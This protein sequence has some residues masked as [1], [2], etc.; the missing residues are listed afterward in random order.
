[1]SYEKLEKYKIII[2][3]ELKDIYLNGP[4]LLKEPICYIL[5]GGG[6]RLRPILCLLS[7]ESLN[8]K[9]IN[10]EV[11]SVAIAVEL[12]HIFTLIHDDIMDSDTMRHG[13]ET[14]HH[15]WNIPIGILSG[16]AVLALA[17]KKINY[18]SNNIKENFNKALLKV[19]EGQALDIEYE[20]FDS[21]SID[22]YFASQNNYD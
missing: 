13:K 16:D 19:C 15:K 21:L 7:F 4:K 8:K 3:N 12:L 2:N 14:I 11:V 10:N 1:M 22:K 5:N 20:S 17:L 9:K 6:K 18:S